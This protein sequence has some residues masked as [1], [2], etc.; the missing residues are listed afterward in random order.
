MCICTFPFPYQEC[1]NHHFPFEIFYSFMKIQL[2][3]YFLIPST[4]INHPYLCLV[5]MSQGIRVI[6]STVSVR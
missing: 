1:L 6:S 3:S 2:K 4:R 5:T